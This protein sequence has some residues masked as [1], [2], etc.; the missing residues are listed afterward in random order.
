MWRS[1]ILWRLFGAYGVLLA[2]SFVGLG[3]LVIGRMESHLLQ[4]LQ[5]ELEVK[6]LLLQDLVVDSLKARAKLKAVDCRDIHLSVSSLKSKISRLCGLALLI[7]GLGCG[8]AT[9]PSGS[10]GA[11]GG[12]GTTGQAGEGGTTSGGAGFGGSPGAG[13]GGGIAGAAGDAGSGGTTAGGT[14]GAGG[15]GTA[16]EGGRGG[17]G[18]GV[19][20]NGATGGAIAGA[21]GR[22]GTSGA[23]GR[24]GA[25]GGAGGGM[26]GRAGS[27]GSVPLDPTLLAL[28]SGTNPIKCT[29]P[30]ATNTIDY[31][32]TV[33]LGDPNAA[34]VARVQAELYRIVVPQT[35]IAAGQLV[36]QTFAVNVRTE[37]H[38]GYSADGKILDLLIDAPA[39]GPAPRLH[40]LGVAAA[41]SIPTIFVA[42]DST[43]CDWAPEKSIS[44]VVSAVT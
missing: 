10:P 4:E 14:G 13:T 31:T 11:G 9:G 41:P 34:S 33:E 7:G 39:G 16:G 18:T 32:V 28:C 37:A 12:A 42:G 30:V 6:T 3:W 24:G 27:G 23:G 26:A 40:G 36:Q 2:A 29:I 1:R 25:N 20:G 44:A 5:H 38:D 22:G 43:V 21:S 19:A 15:A 8:A 17:S 35:S